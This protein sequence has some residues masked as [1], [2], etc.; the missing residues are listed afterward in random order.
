MELLIAVLEPKINLIR[1]DRKCDHY[2]KNI[3]GL[4]KENWLECKASYIQRDCVNVHEI[5]HIIE[6]AYKYEQLIKKFI[7]ILYKKE[8]IVI[9]M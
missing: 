4:R 6:L 3:T 2:Q 1:F 8:N 9:I 5:E 7:S